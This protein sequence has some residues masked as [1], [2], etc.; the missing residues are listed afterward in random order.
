[1]AGIDDHPGSVIRFPIMDEQPSRN[2][3]LVPVAGLAVVVLAATAVGFWPREQEPA[4]AT[5]V[6]SASAAVAPVVPLTP[7]EQ[8]HATLATQVRALVDG[9]EAGWLAS[10]DGRLRSRYQTMFRNLRALEITAA[11]AGI[12]GK[13]TAKGDTMTGQV[14]LSYCFGDIECPAYRQDP[15][16]GPPKIINT[17]TWTSRNGSWMI[18]KAVA[19][20]GANRL[21][22]APWENTKLTVAV[23]KRVV[24]AAPASQSASVE[25]VLRLAENAAVYADRYAV[26]LNNPQNRYRIYLADNKAYQTWY[27][28]SAPWSVGYRISLNGI[29]S[30]IVVKANRVLQEDDQYVTVVLQHEMGHAVTLDDSTSNGYARDSQWLVEGVA[31]YIGAQP[32]KV[33][34]T[35]SRTEL[36]YVQSR[37]LAVK[38]IAAPAVS[39]DSGDLAVTR[40]YAT[41]HFAVGCMAEKYGETKT[42]DFVALVL[43]EGMER[44]AAAQVAFRQPFK[45]IDKACMKWIK[46]K[47]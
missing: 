42:L 31:E 1:M 12:A 25:R 7:S 10:V 28:G 16:T 14:G 30:D 27:S 20:G 34:N 9:D 11:D 23:G 22:P 43:R 19:A 40:L 21:Q 47:L 39:D 38:T 29:D 17:I 13:L 5:P 3:P 41:G 6:A 45:A 15:E 32:R 37:G 44:D 35:S 36:R 46:Q 4:T 18:T 8:V 33:Q 26:K 2:K 24:V